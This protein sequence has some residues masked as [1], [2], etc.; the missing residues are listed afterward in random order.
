[1][2]FA[3]SLRTSRT[4]DGESEIAMTTEAAIPGLT[5]QITGRPGLRILHSI[6][7]VNPQSG[8][9][10]EGIKQ[11]SKPLRALGCQVEVVSG[12]SP[13]EPFIKEFPVPIHAL[14]PTKLPLKYGFVPRLSR[15]M[16]EHASNY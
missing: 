15:W 11:L 16:R 4:A 2:L 14:G 13:G 1:M 7:T 8:G 12:D 5:S 10:I 3:S 6:S 9:P